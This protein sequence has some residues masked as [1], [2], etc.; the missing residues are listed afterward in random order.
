MHAT[1]FLLFSRSRSLGSNFWLP[2]A[3][4]LSSVLALILSLPLTM[5]LK[6]PLDFVTLTEALPFIVCTVGFDKP[7]RL[8]K[9]VFRHPHVSTPPNNAG[10]TPSNGQLKPS[11]TVILECL[12]DVYNPIV[13]DYVLEIAV[14]IVGANSKVVGL[15]DICA[16]AAVLLAID[17]VLMCTFLSAVFVIMVEVSTISS[18]QTI[19]ITNA[20]ALQVRRIG[21]IRDKAQSRTASRV[22]S[23]ATSPRHGT[24]PLADYPSLRKR[25]SQSVLGT[26]GSELNIKPTG[27]EEK[28][29]NPV[30]RLKLL[31][32]RDSRCPSER[33]IYS[34]PT[35]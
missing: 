11:G 9:A 14:L 27:R 17:C 7:L 24:I 4:F 12:Q 26:K 15:R 31:L 6:I 35:S 30:A 2:V 20:S 33:S 16:F 28:P 19:S 29:A 3:I 5:W 32:V 22:G 34:S 10:G 23:V 8:A 1:F 13:R 21:I 18:S 25:I